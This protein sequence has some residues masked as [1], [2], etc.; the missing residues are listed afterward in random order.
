MSTATGT[1]LADFAHT[2]QGAGEDGARIALENQ[3]APPLDA[4][5]RKVHL[6]AINEPIFM[7]VL[8]LVGMGL[9]RW[10]T[11]ALRHM[12]DVAHTTRPSRRCPSCQLLQQRFGLLEVG[13][14]QA[15]GEPPID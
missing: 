5:E 7:A 11:P 2:S 9:R 15:L 1:S 12:G 4:V 13:G 8:G 3:D 10:L 14:V 6:A